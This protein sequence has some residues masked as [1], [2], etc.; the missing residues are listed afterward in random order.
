[1]HKW[2]IVCEQQL[3]LFNGRKRA[4]DFFPWFLRCMAIIHTIF[5]QWANACRTIAFDFHVR[6]GEIKWFPYVCAE[7][8]TFLS[9]ACIEH[10]FFAFNFFVRSAFGSRHISLFCASI[11]T[12]SIAYAYKYVIIEVNAAKW[13]PL[14]NF[15]VVVV[16]VY[17]F[18]IRM[19]ATVCPS[20]SYSHTP[21]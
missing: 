3:Y 1:M 8:N 9:H 2:F 5:Y 19:R 13:I 17:F 16:G 12:Y 7:L 14:A 6:S 4:R 15:V 11:S 10:F 20:L 21:N 18:F